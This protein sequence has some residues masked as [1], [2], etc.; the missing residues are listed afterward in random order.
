M[1]DASFNDLYKLTP[2]GLWLKLYGY[3]PVGLANCI[4][5][6]TFPVNFVGCTCK[7]H[8]IHGIS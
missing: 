7:I 4:L 2:G 1:H 8:Q 5:S 3:K 6:T